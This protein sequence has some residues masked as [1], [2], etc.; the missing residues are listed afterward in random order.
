M[1]IVSVG[2]TDLITTGPGG[3]WSSETAWVDAGGGVSPDLY[4][5]PSWQVTAAAGCADCSQA[6]RN[7]PDVSANSN[8]TFYV[9]ADQTTCSSNNYGGTSFAAPMWAGFMALINQ[10]ATAGGGPL[11]GFLNPA[12]YP[13]YSSDAYTTA[14]HDIV[15]GSNGFPAT[16][17]F[18]LATG[19]GSPNG[20]GLIDALTAAF[21]T[22][23]VSAPAS[24]NFGQQVT[25][26]ATVTAGGSSSIPTGS[27]NFLDGST[28]I[29]TSTLNG[30][31]VATLITSSL[32]AG[33]H[34]I[35]AV[36]GGGGGFGGST[37][38]VI[39]LNIADFTIAANPTTIT[40]ASPGQSGTSTITVT[41]VGGFSQALNFACTG[42]PSEASCAFV[43]TDT[44]ATLTVSTKAPSVR[45]G[46][47][48][49]GGNGKGLFYA[50]LCPG[51]LGLVF[52]GIRKPAQRRLRLLALICAVGF[53]SMAIACGSS[54]KTTTPPPDPGTPAGSSTV[55]VTA[56]AGTLSNPLTITVTV[57]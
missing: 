23:S 19:L 26:T 41:A 31:G 7:G 21:T 43:T 40:I 15:A 18:D 44:G 49:L 30:T 42:L 22:T 2:G 57:Q 35:T 9:C 53:C 25:I 54:S 52:S 3:A 6:I 51:F 56:T 14:F 4:T 1:N 37:S 12:I 28:S 32:T 34:S 11:I 17:G 55:T 50:L 48:M 45:R 46:A 27:V 38:T 10:Q 16:T 33:T 39:T 20:S 24:V 5:I 47:Q 8:F 13:V 36:Y 29:G